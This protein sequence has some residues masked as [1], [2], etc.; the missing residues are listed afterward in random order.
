MLMKLIQM[1]QRGQI[2]LPFE[3][4]KILG[5]EE[6]VCFVAEINEEGILLK[7]ILGNASR[8]IPKEERWFWTEK[9]QKKEKE[10]DEAIRIGR[11]SQIFETAEEAIASLRGGKL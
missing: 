9:W 7:P 4:R 3:I 1:R 2:T 10:A 11:I 8:Q 5:L 6:G